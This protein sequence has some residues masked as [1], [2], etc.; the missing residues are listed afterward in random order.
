MISIKVLILKKIVT[1]KATQTYNR[2]RKRL[3]S[4]L[5]KVV[6]FSQVFFTFLTKMSMKTS[7]TLACTGF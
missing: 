3:M 4:A 6:S 5:F 7:A 2:K 1:A